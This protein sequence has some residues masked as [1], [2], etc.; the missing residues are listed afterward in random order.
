MSI[1]FF[2]ELGGLFSHF[3]QLLSLRSLIQSSEVECNPKTNISFFE[4]FFQ[5]LGGGVTS[6]NSNLTSDK[7][8]LSDS[9]G[10][11]AR[12]IIQLKSDFG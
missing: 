4:I 1:S 12:Y 11:G 6:A 2:D 5:S 10:G 3:G 8:I 9:G 7:K